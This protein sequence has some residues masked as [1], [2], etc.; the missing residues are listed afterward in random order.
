MQRMPSSQIVAAKPE[1]PEGIMMSRQKEL[2]I[3]PVV[4]LQ[5]MLRR[6]MDFVEP[7]LNGQEVEEFRKVVKDF[8][9]PGGDGEILQKL[10]LERASRNPNWFSEKAIEKFLKSRLPLS[11][12]SMAMSLPRN[13]FPTKKD[14]LRQAAALTAGALNF[15][16]L[17]ESDRFAK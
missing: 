5:D 16:H 8:G 17:I 12:T 13:K 14:Q 4:P 3:L 6:Y 11:S 1:T 7:F 10:L 2:P 15:K 9:K